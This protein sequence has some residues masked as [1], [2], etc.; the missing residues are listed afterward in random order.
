[1]YDMNYKILNKFEVN[2]C[3]E[4]SS[5]QA[6]ANESDEEEPTPMPRTPVKTPRESSF[7]ENN[8]MT[9]INDTL[10]R[11]LELYKLINNTLV[12]MNSHIDSNTTSIK[13]L[14][15]ETFE[16]KNQIFELSSLV[17]ELKEKK[18][19]IPKTSS[20]N[21]LR[22]SSIASSRRTSIIKK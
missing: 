12:D 5:N 16:L 15:D 4:V 9:Y 10:K 17:K 22:S 7:Y 3:Q 14:T 18:K 20:S 2:N 6:E 11:N 1:M 19:E 8:K 13:I 21:S